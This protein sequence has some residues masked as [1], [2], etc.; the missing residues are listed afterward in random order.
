M[1]NPFGRISDLVDGS[2]PL[3]VAVGLLGDRITREPPNEVHP[4]A[5]FGA[6]MGALEERVWAD[7]RDA[8]VL[9]TVVG[10]AV[11]AVAGTRMRSLST[12]VSVVVAGGELRRTARHIAA[13]LDHNDLGLARDRLPALVGRDPSEFD[14]SAISAAAIESVAENSVDAVFAPAFWGLVAGAPGAAAYR[15]I[16]TMDAMV[17]HRSVRY[18]R[19][20]WAAARLDDVAN[21]VPARLFALCVA[22]QQPARAQVIAELVRRDA[23]TH[24]SPNAG[25]AETAMAAAIER[26]LG[27]PLRYGER[28]EQRP[29]LGDGARPQPA[30]VERA[31]RIADRAEWI[32]TAATAAIGL[33]RLRRR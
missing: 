17:G 6:G 12:V 23:S 3:G 24:P 22:V 32:L 30:D 1:R 5:W 7:R 15:A 20:G 28:V 33:A 4:V 8:G 21:W 29:R 26:Q 31:V 25:V 13:A 9:Y 11:G 19:F 16:N 27:G 2:R 18:E 14:A 10:V